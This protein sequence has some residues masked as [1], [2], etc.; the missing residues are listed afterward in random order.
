LIKIESIEGIP[1]TIPGRAP[2]LTSYGSLKSWA[3]TII[4]ITADNGL[5]GYGDVSARVRPET[6]KTFERTL[7]GVSPWST[8]VISARI[9]NW[10]YYPWQ[11]LEPIMAGIEMACLDLQGKSAQLPVYEL[12]GGKVRDRVPVSGYLFYSHA[13]PDGSEQV[14]TP[15]DIVG[16]A[17]RWVENF[18]FDTLK[19]KGGY[20]T[21]ETDRD[22]LAALKDAFG[23]DI[24]LRLDPQGSWTV[25]TAIRIGHDLDK[26]GLE[27][28]E[29]PCL[30]IPA[31]ATVRR[32]VNT[33]LSTNM[34]VTNFEQFGPG[35]TAG[36]VDIVLSDLWY[37]GGMRPTIELDRMCAA[38]GLDI[39][40][41]SGTELG[42]GWAAMIHAGVAM[43]HV[44]LAADAMY[45]HLT[46]DIIVG[47]MLLPKD[48]YISPPEGVGLGIEI[49][50][51]KLEK[52]RKLATSGA[53]ADRF[54]EPSLADSA[55][56]GWYPS[57]PAW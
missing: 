35:L 25:G 29:D 56:P 40:I 37:W 41:H 8:T 26:I 30:G 5:I 36:A 18:G 1:V 17:K 32:A 11:A 34:C 20:F 49:D 19:L 27:Y 13:N 16:L 45:T 39:G 10:N 42:I 48:G 12:L 2:I 44:T 38:T 7:R 23:P 3:R 4:R 46:D 43:P 24:K 31:M 57:M 22:S 52:Y 28:Y 50:E 9:K 15:D 21:P 6:I 14:H 54:V 55:R 33:P 47:E 51:V 53:A